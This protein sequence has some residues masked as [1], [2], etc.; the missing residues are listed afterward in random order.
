M[1][2]A[3]F[4]KVFYSVF[5]GP[6]MPKFQNVREVPKSMLLAMGIISCI[7]IFFGLFPD[8]IVNNIVQPAADALMNYEIYI[9]QVVGVI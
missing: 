4:V 7:I 5:L 6:A 2:L 1:L 9:E 8:L 3:V